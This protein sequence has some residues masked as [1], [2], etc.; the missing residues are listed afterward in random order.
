MA[1]AP[2]GPENGPHRRD[3]DSLRRQ[4]TYDFRLRIFDHAARLPADARLAT[5]LARGGVCVLSKRHCANRGRVLH[6]LVEAPHAARRPLV[7]AGRHRDRFP[8]F[9]I[10]LADFSDSR[11]GPAAD[12]DYSRRLR[13]TDSVALPDPGRPALH[14]RRR[15]SRCA[16]EGAAHLSFAASSA[17]AASGHTFAAARQCL[18]VSASRRRLEI[19]FHHSA[20]ERAGH[21]RVAAN[22]GERESGRRRL[23][24]MAIAAREW[25]G[26]T[27]RRGIR[28]P[29]SHDSL[30]WAHG[31]QSVWRARGI[32]HPQR[33]GDAIDMHNRIDFSHSTFRAARSCGH[34]HRV[35][36][37]GHGGAGISGN[38]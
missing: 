25:T 7:S 12:G 6:G 5:C 22:S 24:N 37:S 20:D 34:R 35:V 23:P 26:D 2:F 27:R 38:S 21:H 11:T 29:V 14:T 32:L 16:F 9:G 19:S 18:R 8:L 10:R 4:Y 31:A 13:I 17:F 1:S 3:R 15:D 33:S 28:Q 30:F 36:W